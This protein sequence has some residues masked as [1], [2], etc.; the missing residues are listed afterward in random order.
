MNAPFATPRVLLLVED[1]PADVDF[2]R[3]AV[4]GMRLNLPLAVVSDGEQAIDYLA[5]QRQYAD[6]QLHPPPSL[7]LLDLRL[8][9]TSGLD[10]LRW[11]HQKELAFP[12]P[13]IIVF[14]SSAKPDDLRQAKELGANAYIIKPVSLGP[15]K[16]IVKGLGTLWQNPEASIH[17]AL[18]W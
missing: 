18:G 15:L 7:I 13:K 4:A 11:I 16:Q 8:P 14:T 10:V 6:R 1:N 12:P 3:R 17:G 5:G 9:R 2:F